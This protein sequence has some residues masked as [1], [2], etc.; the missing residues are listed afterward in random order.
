MPGI[1]RALEETGTTV[2]RALRDAGEATPVSPRRDSD[3]EVPDART[4]P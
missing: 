3:W 2:G 4:L 1:R